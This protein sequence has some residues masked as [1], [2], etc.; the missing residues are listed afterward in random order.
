MIRRM[1]RS[2]KTP[3]VGIAT[4]TVA[5]L[6]LAVAAAPPVQA[7][8]LRKCA[9]VIGSRVACYETVWANGVPH[10]MTFANQQFTGA[11]ASATLDPFYVLAPQTATPQGTAP[12]PHDHVVGD[13]P[14]QNHGDY[15][16]QL[17]AYFVLCSA[18]GL[19][20]GGCVPTM[21]AIPGLGTLP[22][23]RTVNGQ[24]L[25][26]VAPIEAAANAGLLTLFDTGGVIVGAI[27]HGE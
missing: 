12:F 27:K 26:A 5:A 6:A 15:S 22:F 25:T 13:V 24:L 21:T 16:V 7:A 3:R 10:R 4:L 2:P 14:P 11:P 18:P 23:A 19:A 8:G 17:H 20:S 1:T 9:D